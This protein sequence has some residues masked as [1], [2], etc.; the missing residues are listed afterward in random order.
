MAIGTPVE[1]GVH[2][3]GTAST[4]NVL[5]TSAAAPAG[6]AIIVIIQLPITATTTPTV[7]D[8]ASNSYTVTTPQAFGV[9]G[10]L[11]V[12]RCANPAA[13]SSGSTI[14]VSWSGSGKS[15]IG[16]CSVSGLDPTAPL[17][18]T[19]TTVTGTGASATVSTG[20]LSQADEIVFGMVATSGTAGAFT[21]AT[22]FTAFSSIGVGTGN[23]ETR[24]G[25]KIVSSTSS[26][27]Y[28]P[29]WATSRIY[30]ANVYSFKAAA[31]APANTTPPTV[32]G[33]T[34]QGQTLSTTNG[35]WSGAP[36]SYTYQWFRGTSGIVGA[37]AATY[38]LI[39]L[40]AGQTIYCEVTATNAS[41]SAT[42]A[43]NTVGPITGLA[44]SNTVLPAITGGV[45]EG[46]TLTCSNGTWANIPNSY[47]FQWKRGGVAISGET[48]TT[49]TAVLAD[50]GSTLTCAVTATNAAGSTTA[51]STATSA[52]VNGILAAWA[53]RDTAG[54][55]TDTARWAAITT[56][57]GT[58]AVSNRTAQGGVGSYSIQVS[59]FWTKQD[60][61]SARGYN[62]EVGGFFGRVGGSSKVRIFNLPASTAVNLHLAVGGGAVSATNGFAV[63]DG[64]PDSGGALLKNQTGATVAVDKAMDASGA[65][66]ISLIGANWE[67]TNTPLSV[68]TGSG[69]EL[70]I[71]QNAAG[72]SM[73]LR[74]VKITYPQFD[75]RTSGSGNYYVDASAP[76]DNADGA[77]AGAAWLHAPNDPGAGGVV[78]IFVPLAGAAVNFAKGGRHRPASFSGR[79]H[80]ISFSP[81][82]N[83]NMHLFAPAAGASGNPVTYAA[84]GS[85]AA[86]IIDGSEVIASWSA[87]TSGD[88]GTNPN[89]SN[90]QKTTLAA[91]VYFNRLVSE[92]GT[93]LYP[94]CWPV[95][96]NIAG[97]DN[98]DSGTDAFND[99]G[100][101]TGPG[102]VSAVFTEGAPNSGGT[103]FKVCSYSGGAVLSRYGSVSI[104]DYKIVCR[105]AG[106]QIEE[107]DILTHVTGTGAFTFNIPNASSLYA[108]T[109]SAH[110]L[111]QVRYHPFDLRKT[112]QYAYNSARTVAF[113][114]FTSGERGVARLSDGI[115]L[116]KS[117]I[118]LRD[119]QFSRFALGGAG[120]AI[121]NPDYQPIDGVVLSN[122]TIT[123][124]TDTN[125]EG[126][127]RVQGGGS[128]WALSDITMT[129][130]ITQAGLQ[131]GNL[132]SS[133]FTRIYFRNGGRTA[134]Y[135]GGNSHGN[136]VTDLDAADN[137][138]IHGNGWSSYQQTY[139]NTLQQFLLTN[140]ANPITAQGDAPKSAQHTIV[141]G[142]LC[143]RRQ[144]TGAPTPVSQF[145]MRIDGYG[146]SDS[147]VEGVVVGLGGP[148]IGPN[149]DGLVLRNC[150]FTKFNAVSLA[151]LNHVKFEN[152]L[153]LSNNGNVT[154][155][156]YLANIDPASFGVTFASGAE[157][158]GTISQTMQQ[159]L[160]RDGNT[161]NYLDRNIGLSTVSGRAWTVPAY[162]SSFSLSDCFLS[163]SASRSGVQADVDQGMV[164]GT[165]PG[166][167]LSLPTGVADNNL[168]VLTNGMWS[169][170]SAAPAAGT[171]TMTVRQTNSHPNL[172]GSGT[173]DTSFTIIVS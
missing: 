171:Y 128:G 152:V 158:N 122:L 66:A 13:L 62:P 170:A 17:D 4:S 142:V 77:S 14:T 69:G 167:V 29:S 38:L 146:L 110:F 31:L 92:A 166:S 63:Y 8:T 132:N 65:S 18:V 147:L 157:W 35:A 100:V 83:P 12:A 34:T 46:S 16:A 125:R 59:G 19:G 169:W 28:N 141:N 90:C 107:F 54:S 11:C 41:G 24:W 109:S 26:V 160:T 102:G 76:N 155:S 159:T 30:G 79:N 173:R 94:A 127:I 149:N 172:L 163:S 47:T 60:Y 136:M 129:D 139:G 162:G 85:G 115:V 61:S 23:I 82:P 3:Q 111:W 58:S 75:K 64:D 135:S 144:P 43:S 151:A 124:C 153:V 88:M 42:Q 97:F 36:T 98:S 37:T 119:L 72:D 15:T 114:H 161:S 10:K 131:C 81:N 95:P 48:N 44:P 118:T 143:G 52:I 78:N 21:Q 70:W 5:T 56:A 96:G 74:A 116:N 133:T 7:A 148:Y 67:A 140:H 53:F 33:A 134:W 164:M 105:M 50:I 150:V 22:G 6:D 154:S 106:N 87:A 123:Q 101:S 108:S 40:D 57:D 20:G 32:S 168:F 120:H 1:L 27:T 49:Y 130:N 25:Y 73:W 89:Y 145:A 86:P 156:N 99:E 121:L 91:A 45:I 112:G 93:R 126:V 137:G 39:D 103:G 51:T 104:K 138:A 68:T 165:Q 71:K 55:V 9:T 84:Y 117:Y 80:G 113:G 2:A